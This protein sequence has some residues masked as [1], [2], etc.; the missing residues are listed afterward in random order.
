MTKKYGILVTCE[1]DDNGDVTVTYDDV[2]LVKDKTWL[3]QGV[4]TSH[5]IKKDKLNE[6]PDYGL[7][8]EV[9]ERG[10]IPLSF[11]IGSNLLSLIQARL[12]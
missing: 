10:K 1:V 6:R 8:E 2:K 11:G 5:T 4:V 7:K 3:Y 12:L 9:R